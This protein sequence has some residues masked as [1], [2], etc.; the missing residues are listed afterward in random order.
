MRHEHPLN[1]VAFNATGTR[2]VT[3]SNEAGVARLWDAARGA[4]IGEAMPH[5]VGDSEAATFSVD[6]S[7]LI[8]KRGDTARI[9]ESM[10]GKP[11][12]KALKHPGGV[13]SAAFS[14]DGSRILT[15]TEDGKARVWSI[16]AD[17]VA[18]TLSMKHSQAIDRANFSPDGTRIVTFAAWSGELWDAATG[19]RVGALPASASSD[20]EGGASSTFSPMAAMRC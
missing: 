4:P 5:S 20:A 9:W 3:E 13:S 10:S 1:G 12:G 2:I 17:R 6:G 16:A 8:T 14:P 19:R 11:I 18:S 15:V 7:R